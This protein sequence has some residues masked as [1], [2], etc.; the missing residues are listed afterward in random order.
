MREV[1]QRAGVAVS[2]V[3]R[4]MSNPDRISAATR[5][6]VLSAARDLG[7]RSG[8]RPAA[9]RGSVALVVPDIANPFYFDLIRGS[10]ERLRDSGYTQMLIDTEE[11]PHAEAAALDALAGS[12]AGAI[13]AATRLTDEQVRSMAER[14]P[15]VTVNRRID[16][17]PAVLV[18]TP[19]AYGQ[20]VAH[21]VSLG[22]Q[23]IAYL[24][25]PDG[26]ASSGR[27]WAAVEAAGRRLDVE[28]T[29]L[30]P[31]APIAESGAAAADALLAARASA[32]LAF[33]DLLAIGM[34]QRFAERGIAVPEQVSLV[35]CDDIFGSDFCSPPLTTITAPTR[36]LGSE[37]TAMLL[38]LAAGTE[39]RLGRVV[40]LP[41]HLTVRS[42]TGPA[43]A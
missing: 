39:P 24:A 26:S 42:S 37:A 6:Q 20:A 27:R 5:Q 8:A 18:D 14:L 34:L 21:L 4:V 2:T 19:T 29:R 31:F 43:P 3:S 11:S 1:A 40:E 30:G 41:V 12:C 13:L 35:G 32:G 7:Y 17:L 10:Q 36:R 23:R 15:V 16:Q 38:A 28:V 9:G 33:N 22:H 25:G